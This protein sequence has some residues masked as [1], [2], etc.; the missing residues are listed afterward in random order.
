LSQ[1]PVPGAAA[2]SLRGW[3]LA[4]QMTAWS[5]LLF[6]LVQAAVALAVGRAAADNARRTLD[7]S[8]VVAERVWQQ[9]LEQRAHKL[10]QSAAVLAT[11]FGFRDAVTSGDEPT[12]VSALDNHGARIGASVVALLDTRLVLRQVAATAR[13]AALPRAWPQL[14]AGLPEAL[15]TGG[16][17]L[18]LV[19]GRPH[20]FVVAPVRAPA[21]VGHV[22]MGFELDA[23]VLGQLHAV[24]GQQAMLVLAPG[25]T[26]APRLLQSTLPADDQAGRLLR[27]GLAAAAERTVTVDGAAGSQRV[28]TAVVAA[29]GGETALLLLVGDIDAALE[30]YSTLG[31]ELVVLTALGVLGFGA[32]SRWAARRLTRPLG[33]LVSASERLAAGDY[34]TPLATRRDGG[35]VGELSRAFEHMR[36]SVATHEREIRDLAYRDRLTGLPNRLFFREAVA[37]ELAARR[38]LAVVMLDLDRFKHVNAVLG[39]ALGDRLLQAL[40]E[41]LRVAAGEALVARLGGD[42]FVLLA[43]GAGRA[44]GLAL[45]ERVAAA[46]AEPL[47]L[48][49]QRVDLGAGFGIA[50][51][52]EHALEPDALLSRAEVAMVSAKRS[53]EGVCVYEPALDGTSGE[54]LSLLSALRHAVVHDELRLFLQ[55]KV[56][57]ADG[58]LCGAEALVRWQHPQRGLVPPGQFIPFAEQTGFVRQLTLWVVEAAARS[59]PRL[60]ALGVERLAVNLS[61]RDLMDVELPSKL[62]TLLAR[63]GAVPGGFCLEITES[64]IMDDPA[65]AEATLNRLAAR[66][67]KLSIDDFGTGYSS[68]AYLRR[69]PVQELKIDRSF[70]MGMERESGDATIVRSTIDLA[71]TLGLSVVAEGVENATLLQM[72][73]RLGCDEA[74]GYHLGRPMPVAEFE[75]CFAAAPA[76]AAS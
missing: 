31:A 14:Q 7:E 75:R 52:P 29:G 59:Q 2:A 30:P 73:E 32:A 33:Q 15:R 13:G 6:L 9:L 35:E 21:L 47:V 25:P 51:A 53:T 63:H 20:Q 11:D 64:A 28:R 61:T 66:G 56:R 49:D 10:A 3:R 68:L 34:E 65:R 8:L 45:A 70:V 37:A 41:R 57:V 71:H 17:T 48:E 62:D 76:M 60:Q 44:G 27:P 69:L 16:S 55:P 72:L 38:P 24:T 54:T 26:D 42:E 22:L 43:R 46:L 50:C 18:G 5:L 12:I 23:A 19:D 1:P 4:G 39:Y 74:Q 58:S 36:R 67:Y 40:S